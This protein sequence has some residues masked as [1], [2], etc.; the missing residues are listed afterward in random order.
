MAH[1]RHHFGAVPTQSKPGVT[2]TGHI[3]NTVQL[4]AK[5]VK[6][7]INSAG[8]LVQWGGRT[9]QNLANKI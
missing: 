6:W 9:L 5:P 4:A 1:H 8:L 2:V 7:T 3:S